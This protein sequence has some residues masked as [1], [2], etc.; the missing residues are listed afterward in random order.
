MKYI[1][2]NKSA[3]FALNKLAIILIIHN[4]MLFYYYPFTFVVLF[5]QY[6]A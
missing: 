6:Y 3:S 1:F 2:L 4:I 5:F